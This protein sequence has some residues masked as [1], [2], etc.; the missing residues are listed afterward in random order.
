MFDEIRSYRSQLTGFALVW[1][2]CVFGLFLLVGCGRN[3]ADQSK[4]SREVTVKAEPTVLALVF[5]DLTGSMDSSSVRM[6][7]EAVANILLSLPPGSQFEIFPIDFSGRIAPI[8]GTT[9]GKPKKP[10]EVGKIKA[11]NKDQAIR[12]G[13]QLLDLYGRK[14]APHPSR[15]SCIVQTLELADAIFKQYRAK[16]DQ[17]YEFEIVY[18]SDML[19]DCVNSSLG[20]ASFETASFSDVMKEVSHFE[21]KVDIGFA[22]LSI[23]IPARPYVE[24]TRS[25][26]T[27]AQLKEVWEKIFRKVGFDDD[28]ISEWNF[29]STVP[30]RFSR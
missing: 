9:E 26:L 17:E 23:I 18:V 1:T 13:N 6:S 22:R 19:E 15:N 21:P 14:F 2:T 7:A 5:C 10:S 24:N 29:L 12:V 25:S 27:D 28:K 16:A 20:A 30:A 4:P 8:E 11:L 3:E